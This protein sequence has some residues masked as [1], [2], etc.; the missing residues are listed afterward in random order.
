MLV[1]VQRSIVWLTVENGFTCFC[2]HMNLYTYV[3]A[4]AHVFTQLTRSKDTEVM[5]WMRKCEKAEEKAEELSHSLEEARVQI[6]LKVQS[7]GMTRYVCVSLCLCTCVRLKT[8]M[9]VC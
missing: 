6:E 7:A 4:Y 2:V 9:L 1:H 3:H 5:N 8:R